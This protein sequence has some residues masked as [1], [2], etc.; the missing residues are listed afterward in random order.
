MLE[1]TRLI[2]GIMSADSYV[3]N[4]ASR[5]YSPEAT[6]NWC[7]RGAH[8]YVHTSDFRGEFKEFIDIS[9][10]SRLI[11]FPRKRDRREE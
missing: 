8:R 5:Q 7:F 6:S 11:A 10:G 9:I 4:R 1:H 3:I 2:S